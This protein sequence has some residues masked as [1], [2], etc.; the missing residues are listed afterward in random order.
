[1]ALLI[2]TNVTSE[3]EHMA[4][5]ILTNFTSESEH[6]ALLFFIDGELN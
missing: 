4:L 6:M 5:L 3:S 1:M 2:L